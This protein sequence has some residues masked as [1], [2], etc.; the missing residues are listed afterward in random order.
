[1][2]SRVT[3]AE[4]LHRGAAA[5]AVVSAGGYGLYRALE[6]TRKRGTATPGTTVQSFHSRPDLRPPVVDVLTHT[7]GVAPGLVF[8]APSSGPGQRGV[9]IFDDEGELVYFHPTAPV[10]AMNFRAGS[11]HGRPVLTWWEGKTEHG[12]GEGTH[13]I[14]DSSYRVVA[15]IPSGN[16][17]PSDLHEWELTPRGTA[18][19]TAWELETA[20]L[21]SVGGGAR[22]AVI[23]G[24]VQELAVPSGK[25]LFEWRSLDHVPVAESH[26]RVG[27]RFDY[28]HVNAIDADADGSLLVSARNTWAVYKV[29]QSSGK[30]LW[31]L[32]GKKS[33]FAMGPGTQFAWQHDA[34][35]HGAGDRLIS[36]FDD[37]ARP[38]VH[39]ESRAIVLALD[40]ARRTATLQRSITHDPPVL[41]WALG[42]M[43]LL[44]NGNALV[45]WGTA[46]YLSEYSPDGKV[47]FDAK[48]PVNG[49]NYRTLRF[50]WV[51]RPSVPPA[52]ASAQDA[53]W[54]SWNGSTETA[55]WQLHTGTSAGSLAHASATRRTGF[56][57]RLDVP[58]GARWAAV[59]A[60]DTDGRE[61]GRSAAVR[62]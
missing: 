46:P 43:Q 15:R 16:G 54:A 37:G 3:R 52:L 62:V 61:L 18:L 51:G 2:T 57:T 34:R 41:A 45:G 1:M 32:G 56:E 29:D 22:G 33:D 59:A 7:D 14:L 50:P 17:R 39:K 5:A 48:L 55:S 12:L 30:V 11:Y 35:H 27:P 23:G 44:G 47:M 9:M 36:L 53:L 28:F 20:D 10:T 40:H 4:F 25:V 42:S 13:V 19:A 38:A 21:R 8:A 58:H 49:E 31:R 6:G 24:V 60:L 26:Q